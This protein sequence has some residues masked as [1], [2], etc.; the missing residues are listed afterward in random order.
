MGSF[1][2]SEIDLE[3]WTSRSKVVNQQI[4]AIDGDL[5]FVSLVDLSLTP[6]WAILDKPYNV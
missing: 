2:N 1:T 6:V 5:E 3:I 4:H